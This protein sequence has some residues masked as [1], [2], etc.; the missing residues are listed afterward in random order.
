MPRYH[1]LLEG[2]GIA[3]AGGIPEA[4]SPVLRGFFIARYVR[5]PGREEAVARA[6][7]MVSYDWTRGAYAHL[8]E[9]PAV[10]VSDVQEVGFWTWLFSRHTGY[11]FHPGK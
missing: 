11:I 8:K 5:A 2:S 9:D 4:K 7:A 3:I 6:R 10:T 1:V